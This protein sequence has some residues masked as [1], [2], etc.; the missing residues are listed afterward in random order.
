MGSC[1]SAPKGEALVLT[2][3][4]DEKNVVMKNGPRSLLQGPEANGADK[5]ALCPPWTGAS[6]KA[7]WA[8]GLVVWGKGGRNESSQ[9]GHGD[10]W[11]RLC[12]ARGQ[13]L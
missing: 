4:L 2:A 7:S 6:S 5:V 11:S 3:I 12:V 13:H 9:E 8:P 1:L 10:T